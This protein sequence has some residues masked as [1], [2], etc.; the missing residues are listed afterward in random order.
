MAAVKIRGEGVKLSLHLPLGLCLLIARRALG[1][2]DA[3]F[4]AFLKAHGREVKRALKQYKKQNGRLTLVDIESA[5]GT[6]V[7]III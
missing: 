7:K 5:D 3:E 1:S 6:V 4:V 2:K